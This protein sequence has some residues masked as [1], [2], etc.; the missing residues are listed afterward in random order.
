MVMICV[1]LVIRNGEHL[2]MCLLV[3]CMSS[4]EK[5][6]VRFTTHFKNG[7]VC[8]FVVGELYEFFMLLNINHLSDI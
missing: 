5:C 2:F 7:H 3:I 6:L 4:K 1:S 8:F